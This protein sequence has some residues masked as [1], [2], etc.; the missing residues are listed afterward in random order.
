LP[1]QPPTIGGPFEKYYTHYYNKNSMPF[2]ALII[3]F[4]GIPL[5]VFSRKSIII[6]SFLGLHH[7]KPVGYLAFSLSASLL[8]VMVMASSC[9][10]LIPYALH[11]LNLDPAVAMGPF[12]TITN[13]ILGL[14]IYLLITKALLF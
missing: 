12:I 6:F 9:G 5:S 1:N 7:S 3:V 14:S 2:I 8:V 10:V 11:K 13:D 4:F